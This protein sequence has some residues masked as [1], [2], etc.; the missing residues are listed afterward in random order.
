MGH[1]KITPHKK[2]TLHKESKHDEEESC[3]MN[4]YKHEFDNHKKGI[5]D[6]EHHT[7]RDSRKKNSTNKSGEKNKHSQAEY[8]AYCSMKTNGKISLHINNYT[9]HFCCR[10]CMRKYKETMQI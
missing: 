4:P 2:T 10:T 3:D 5:K 1:T 8:C 6:K 7:I 9:K